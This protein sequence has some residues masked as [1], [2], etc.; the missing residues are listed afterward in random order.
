[1][2]SVIK[3]KPDWRSIKPIV[4]LGILKRA[5]SPTVAIIRPNKVI[6]TAF[7]DPSDKQKKFFA[8][9][10]RFNKMLKKAVSLEKIKKNKDL[11]H[12]SLVK[13]SRL[14]VMP[15]DSK[16]WKILN[17]I[18]NIKKKINDKNIKKNKKN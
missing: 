2:A 17:K 3:L 15:I 12:L 1:M 6:K 7:V 5:P 16:S 9:Q 18:G 13:Q 8:V 14:S 10:V 4:N 11:Q